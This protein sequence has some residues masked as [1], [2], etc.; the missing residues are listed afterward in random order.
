MEHLNGQTIGAN[1]GAHNLAIRLMQHLVIPAF[2]LDASSRVTIWNHACE[3]FTGI[4]S[5]KRIGTQDHW[6]GLQ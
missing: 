4:P 6:L 5:A 2:I 3:R 1:D